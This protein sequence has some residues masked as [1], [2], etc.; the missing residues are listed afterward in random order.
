M[1]RGEDEL[2]K[3][4]QGRTHRRLAG[5]ASPLRLA[6]AGSIRGAKRPLV[7]FGDSV[8]GRAAE[9]GTPER[10]MYRRIERFERDGMASLFGSDPA[11]DRAKR[12]GLEPAIWRMIVE[13][14]AEHPALNNNE[15]RNIVYVRTGRRLGKHTA[16]RVLS[17]EV[18]PL[19][20]SRL[21]E[22]YHEAPSRREEAREAVV[23]LHL[24]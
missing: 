4:A 6:G 12:R 17:E 13:L 10:T 18:V 5:V 11:A 23:A 16:A 20:L 8:A 1:V 15:I 19:K 21:F 3:A 2:K 14:K 24:E 7:L 22:P 9:T